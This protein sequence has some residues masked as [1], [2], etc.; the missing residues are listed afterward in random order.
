MSSS[1]FKQTTLSF[2]A[3]PAPADSGAGPSVPQEP[4]ARPPPSH[5]YSKL[6][7]N[8]DTDAGR[9][10]QAA[11]LN[12]YFYPEPDKK[13]KLPTKNARLEAMFEYLHTSYPHANQQYDLDNVPVLTGEA[14]VKYGNPYIDIPDP[15]AEGS[16]FAAHA[17][18]EHFNWANGQFRRYDPLVSNSHALRLNTASLLLAAHTLCHKQ[19]TRS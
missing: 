7:L 4:S 9:E 13:G 18:A 17:S 15:G 14:L 6:L 11:L 12:K 16:P 2:R 19:T 1:K 5:R 8:A 3:Q 10:R